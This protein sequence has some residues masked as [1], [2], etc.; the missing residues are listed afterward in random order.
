[1]GTEKKLNTDFLATMNRMNLSGRLL[2][3]KKAYY[4]SCYLYGYV[5]ETGLKHILQKYGTHDGMPYTIG[6]LK[7]FRHNL[8]SLIKEAKKVNVFPEEF[9]LDFDDDYSYICTN[10]A[11]YPKWDP[12]YRYGEHPMWES[13]DWCYH[14]SLEAESFAKFINNYRGEP[15]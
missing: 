5:L 11:G 3:N 15:E 10:V 6:D 14:Y 7:G 9:A 4:V 12:R 8:D 2:Y 13:E 1:M